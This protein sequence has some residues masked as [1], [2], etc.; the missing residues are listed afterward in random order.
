MSA[1]TKVLTALGLVLSLC[2]AGQ[3]ALAASRPLGAESP[4]ALARRLTA[5]AEA[6]DFGE[7]AACLE[8]ATRAEMALGMVAGV[9]MMVSFMQMGAGMAGGMA[10]GMGEAL[11]G[12]ELTPEQKA[13]IEKARK[14]TEEKMA[15]LQ[16][17][18]EA[19]LAKHGLSELAA[20][21]PMPGEASAEE[22]AKRLQGVDQVALLEEL[23]AVMGELSPE[24]KDSMKP[25]RDL[26]GEITDLKVEGDKASARSG[27]HTVSMIKL[28][29][30][31]Y[32]QP[33]PPQPEPGPTGE[34]QEVQPRDGGSRR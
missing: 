22:A 7:I 2:L 4:E 27:Q 16:K 5:A 6:G 25:S 14:E 24:N 10:E 33:K 1:S 29:G 18:F 11:S 3:P 28:D 12:Q 8:P 15:G 23:V 17:R 31:W 13:E 30:R 21:A 19:V 32:L 26:Y 9:G 20:G 34:T